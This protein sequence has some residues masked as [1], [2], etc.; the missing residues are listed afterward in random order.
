MKYEELSDKIKIL[1][2][3]NG[4]TWDESKG[5]V[6]NQNMFLPRRKHIDFYK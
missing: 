1:L 5:Y 4:I 2:K 3:D 6:S